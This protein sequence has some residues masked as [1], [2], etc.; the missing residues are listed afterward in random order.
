MAAPVF[1]PDGY[2]KHFNELPA[3]NNLGTF[4]TEDMV[5]V[6]NIDVTG[7]K[8]VQFNSEVRVKLLSFKT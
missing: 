7:A 3:T 4:L 2:T 6:L 5:R 8:W 1:V